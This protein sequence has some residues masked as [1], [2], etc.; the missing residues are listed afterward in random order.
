MTAVE[1]GITR[2]T[3]GI[4]TVPVYFPEGNETCRYCMFCKSDSGIRF[5]CYATNKILYTVDGIH[6]DCPIKFDVKENVK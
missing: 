4:L 3:T 5:R 1:R 6:D 2:Y